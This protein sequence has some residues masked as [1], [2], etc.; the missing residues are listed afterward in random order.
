VIVRDWLST[1]CHALKG[2]AFLFRKYKIEAH[3]GRGRIVAPGRVEV[4]AADGTG[5]KTAIEAKAIVI[6][7]GSDGGAL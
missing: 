2:V 4:T 5:A 6:A 1:H 3:Y 7:T